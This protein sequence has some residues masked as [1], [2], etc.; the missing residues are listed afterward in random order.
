MR[1]FKV[2]LLG[3]SGVGKSSLMF[4][5]QNGT[6]KT[7]IDSTVGCDFQA[8]NVTLANQ[9]IVRMLVWD[10]A[11]QEVFR[12][13]VPNFVRNCKAAIVCYDVTSMQSY[14]SVT[15]W[16]NL[17]LQEQAQLIIV[18]NK[19]DQIQRR[20]VS[21]HTGENLAYQLNAHAFIEASAVTGGA[22]D[23][24]FQKTAEAVVEAQS[25]EATRPDDTAVSLRDTPPRKK[26]CCSVF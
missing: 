26:P 10:T 5:A 6:H 9:E 22:V 7:D 23:T 2:V 17:A 8:R 12:A 21:R 14:E 16:A 11:G 24:V 15:E 18:G 4:Y 3:D 1:K 25:E 20:V 13:F 19:F